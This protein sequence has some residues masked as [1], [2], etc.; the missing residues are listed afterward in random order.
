MNQTRHLNLHNNNNN[1][2]QQ[3]QQEE[4]ITNFKIIVNGDLKQDLYLQFYKSR[5]WKYKHEFIIAINTKPNDKSD[6]IHE[7]YYNI[8]KTQE[9]EFKLDK[10]TNN[11]NNNNNKK[12]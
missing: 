6:L 7:S 10:N 9:A 4:E 2:Q 11:N 8:L 1:N 3:E 12:K 5:H